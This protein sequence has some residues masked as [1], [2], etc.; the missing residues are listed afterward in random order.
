MAAGRCCSRESTPLSRTSLGACAG[1]VWTA[2]VFTVEYASGV[3]IRRLVGRVPWDY[4]GAA[5]AVNGLI[6]LD[7]APAWFALGL[8]FERAYLLLIGP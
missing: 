7:Y 5:L 8:L 3:F 6:R 1:L 4:S 2:A